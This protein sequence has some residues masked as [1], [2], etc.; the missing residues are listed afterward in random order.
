MKRSYSGYFWPVR[1]VLCTGGRKRDWAMWESFPANVDADAIY[2]GG[3]AYLVVSI[4]LPELLLMLSSENRLADPAFWNTKGLCHPHPRVADEVGRRLKGI[5]CDV[6]RK[7][8]APSAHSADFLRRTIIEAF[9]VSLMSALPR[10][11]R[12]S[13]YTGARLVTEAEDYVDAS[14]GRPVHISEVCYALKASRRS[15]HRA[16]VD[17]L[18]VSPAAYLRR[19]RLSTIRSILSGRDTPVISIAD[20]AFEYGFPEPGRFAAYYRAHFGETPSETLRS[21]S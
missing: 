5:M 20:L 2:G 16:F 4:A 11:S 14:E 21:R 8:N 10:D 17:T 19:R 13:L 1:A 12:R 18:G 3:A 6:E 9:V 7:A 15:L